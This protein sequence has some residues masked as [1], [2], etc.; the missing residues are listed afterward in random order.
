MLLGIDVF[1]GSGQVD[2]SRAMGQGVQFMF[3]KASQG[4]AG[5]PGGWMDWVFVT[6][7]TGARS[8]G[9]LPGGYHWMLKGNGA[10]QAQLFVSS[11]ERVGGPKGLLCAI[12]IEQNSWDQSLNV[13]PQTV[14]DFLAKWDQLTNKQ[15]ILLYGASWYHDSYMHAG[16][17]WPNRPL[18]W[19]GYTGV[20]SMPI[21]N[22]VASVTP[23]YMVPFGGWS[24]YAVRQFTDNALVAGQQYDANVTYLSQ[25]QLSALTVPPVT[26]SG[27]TTMDAAT[28]A[29]FAAL[30]K[31]IT[32]LGNQLVTV[33]QGVPK[34]RPNPYGLVGLR[35]V[36]TRL[37]A[38][39]AEMVTVKAAEVNA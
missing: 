39:E 36:G 8:A 17:R 13:D 22:A 21:A 14:D 35:D 34:G 38:I 30:Q 37:A 33:I 2:W 9:I 23:G 19:A 18:W 25:A 7:V 10:A 1:N 32:D 20:A 28:A 26:P 12:D 29:Q 27:E 11:L 15:P 5:G 6:H 4:W 16:A 3:A 31:Q 24:S